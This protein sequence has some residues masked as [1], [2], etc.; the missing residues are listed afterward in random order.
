[1]DKEQI[2]HAINKWQ[3]TMQ[4]AE[5]AMDDLMKLTGAAPESPLFSAV[6]ALQGLATKQAAE[7]MGCSPDWLEAWWVEH[8]FGEKPFKVR[9]PG[10]AWREI[11]TLEDFAQ[12][13]ADDLAASAREGS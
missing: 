7:I 13:I 8:Y 10:G 2:S 4:A 6:Y 9:F 1:M 12:S 11:T 5:A 3:A